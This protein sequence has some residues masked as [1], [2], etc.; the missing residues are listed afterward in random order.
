[1]DNSD[2]APL[3]PRL[4]ADNDVLQE[5]DV[6]GQNKDS[7][8]TSVTAASDAAT[9]QTSPSAVMVPTSTS[10]STS[11]MTPT[12]TDVQDDTPTPSVLTFKGNELVGPP[13]SRVLTTNDEA[14]NLYWQT[15]ADVKTGEMLWTAQIGDTT[16]FELISAHPPWD[17]IHDGTTDALSDGPGGKST[18]N[19]QNTCIIIVVSSWTNALILVV[20]NG[21]KLT[22]SDFSKPEFTK[23][24]GQDM[25]I[26]IFWTTS[27]GV[28]GNTVSGIFAFCDP[29]LKDQTLAKLKDDMSKN[30]S[31]SIGVESI[32]TAPVP[33][34]S[35]TAPADHSSIAPAKTTSAGDDSDKSSSG[36]AHGGL[37]QGGVIGVAVGA[38]VAGLLIIAGLILLLLRRRRRAKGKNTLSPGYSAQQS[39][40]D[41]MGDKEP[42]SRVVESPHDAH[43]HHLQSHSLQELNPQSHDH[44]QHQQVP[45]HHDMDNNLNTETDSLH[46]RSLAHENDRGSPYQPYHDSPRATGATTAVAG[47]RSSSRAQ[48]PSGVPHSVAHLVEDGMTEEQIRRLE[49]E[50]RELDAEI[51]RSE[52]RKR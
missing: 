27:K 43:A 9:T 8:T 20:T 52:R 33:S 1:M 31:Y 6:T 46:Q 38:A 12:P 22:P 32:T 16:K 51:E 21:T 29:T 50:E 5:T 14:T 15:D 39:T 11:A 37:S 17:P 48:T 4:Y 2:S 26:Q 13:D 19:K 40:N 49:E 44:R 42:H 41:F 18:L 7:G 28:S 30:P 47:E 3:S 36:K 10:T 45:L 34:S 24:L 35:S 25:R 23:F